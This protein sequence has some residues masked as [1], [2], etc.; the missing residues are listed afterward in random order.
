M[1]IDGNTPEKADEAPLLPDGRT[2]EEV[3]RHFGV[4]P[5]RIRQMARELGACRIFGNKM[6]LLPADIEAILEASKPKP[7]AAPYRPGGDYEELLKR[8]DR[9]KKEAAPKTS[10][11]RREPST[12]R[13][14]AELLQLRERMKR[15][16]AARKKK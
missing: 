1:L 13:D 5:R 4:S 12:G 7:R 9:M 15:E 10:K 11:K 16:E 2:P 8:L 6:F 14:T 3:A